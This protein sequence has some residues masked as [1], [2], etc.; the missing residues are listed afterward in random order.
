MK[1]GAVIINAYTQSGGQLNQIKRLEEEFWRL[2]VSL[3]VFRNRFVSCIKEGDVKNSIGKADFVVYLDKDKYYA[4]LLEKAG[5]R[6]FNSANAIE[7]SDDKMLTYITLAKSGIKIPDTVSCPLNYSN[8]DKDGEFLQSVIEFLG[9]PLIVK[10]CHGS[11]GAQVY[12]I[13]G[14]EQLMEIYEHLMRLPHLYQRYLKSSYGKDCRAIVIDGQ[15]VASM[16]RV[17][18]SDFRS[19]LE[20]GGVGEKCDLTEEQKFVAEK[21][22]KILGLEYCG[23]DLLY[24]DK[25]QPVFCE[26]NANAFFKGIERV[27]GTN[28]AG[29]LAEYIY[30]EVYKK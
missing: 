29:R 21:S 24:G 1:K 14:Q 8:V 3:N 5:Y 7:L 17:N 23:I 15:A 18:T 12:K 25:G 11:L 30:G 13:D 2:G 20:Q 19:N 6:L 22:A 27:T 26:A 16:N 10:N 4:R 28:V 9:F